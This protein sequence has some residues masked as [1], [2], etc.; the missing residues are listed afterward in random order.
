VVEINLYTDAVNP[1]VFFKNVINSASNCRTK[2]I[3]PWR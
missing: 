2:A 3:Y 1:T